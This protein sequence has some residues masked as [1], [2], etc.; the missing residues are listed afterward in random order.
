MLDAVEAD[1]AK[2]TGD[3]PSASYIVPLQ[4]CIF[5]FLCKALV[6]A[7]P[8]ADWVVDRFGFTILDVWLALQMLPTQKVGLVQPL[9][10]LLIHSFP[11]PSFVIWPG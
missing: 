9:E 6:G 8:A 2:A 3:K 5:C 7:D 11:L 1:L 4:Q 10:E